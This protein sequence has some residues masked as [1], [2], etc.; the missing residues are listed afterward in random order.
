MNRSETVVVMAEF[1]GEIFDALS[2]NSRHILGTTAILQ[3][4]AT[5]EHLPCVTRPL[6]CRHMD[7]LV[8]CFTGFLD[9]AEI[10]RLVVLVHNMAG[11]IRKDYGPRVTHLV[12]NSSNSEKYRVSGMMMFT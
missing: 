7:K 5:D 3:S 12:A 6:F 9:K 4:A 1:E 8:I 11:S 10:K 2:S